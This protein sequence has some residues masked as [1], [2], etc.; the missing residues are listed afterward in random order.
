MQFKHLYEGR[1][2]YERP[3]RTYRFGV[4]LAYESIIDAENA[5]KARE[6]FEEDVRDIQRGNPGLE[7][8]EYYV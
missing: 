2:G 4:Y 1:S 7:V 6:A 3:T 8:V 5:E